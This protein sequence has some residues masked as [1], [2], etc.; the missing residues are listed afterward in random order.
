MIPVWE[1][2][3]AAA[4]HSVCSVF[5]LN[6][7]GQSGQNILYLR[8]SS[9]NTRLCL[10]LHNDKITPDNSAPHTE[11][12]NVQLRQ[13]MREGR[14][15]DRG[16]SVWMPYFVPSKDLRVPSTSININRQKKADPDSLSLWINPLNGPRG[17]RDEVELKLWKKTRMLAG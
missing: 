14:P 10:H 15:R 5:Y 1:Q 17:G 9:Q 13:G 11:V 7:S 8:G 4:S 16:M 12:C 3:H 2:R 6:I